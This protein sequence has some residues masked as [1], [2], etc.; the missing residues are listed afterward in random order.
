MNSGHLAEAVVALQSGHPARAEALV[1]HHLGAAPDDPDALRLL[2]AVAVATGKFVDAEPLLERAIAVRPDFALAHADLASLLCR[3]ARA[4]D[5]LAILDRV[6][7]RAPAE[8]WPLSIKTGVLAAERRDEEALAVH[9]ELVKRAPRVAL[10]WTNYAH[11]LH[12]TGKTQA[13]LTT[14]RTALELDP[15][16]GSAWLG[17]ANLRVRAF[18]ID[19]IRSMEGALS[20]VRD[21]SQR[22]QML[23]AL[24]RAC[25]D[26][27]SFGQAFACYTKANGERAAVTPYDPQILRDAVAAHRALDRGFFSD[28]QGAG[29][30]AGDAIFIVG[31]PRSGSTLVEQMLSSHPMVEATG[32]LFELQEIAA[33]IGDGTWAGL[34]AAIAR[35]TP[36]ERRD[37][38]QRYLAATRRYRRTDRPYFT[39]K[40]PANWRFVALIQ[41]ILPNAR[42]VDVRRAALPCCVSAFST[43]FNRQTSFPATLRD[44]GEYYRGY[45]DVSARIDELLPGRVHRLSYEK[46]V[47]HPEDT[48]RHLLGHLG[49]P[50]APA[51]LDF[52]NNLRAVHTPSAAQVRRPIDR[53]SLDGWRDFELWLAPL[54][55]GLAPTP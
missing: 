39:D 21:P 34:P 47:D 46:L 11:A 8:I 45:V 29:H 22:A 36:D 16:S 42:I 52:H 18:G 13:A 7:E 15:S 9:E 12:A 31:M 49:I 35:L 33:T 26:R 53:S 27:S 41:L 30:D 44:L 43:Y 50:F 14:Y 23:F 5:A 3:M 25:A 28:R 19:D 37:L 55:A 38:G 10:L 2:A 17:I 6:I 48:M 4:D 20:G 51:C 24:G 1:R 40:M 54:K 32:E